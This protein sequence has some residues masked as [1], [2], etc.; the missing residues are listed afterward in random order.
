MIVFLKSN[1]CLEVAPR[2]KKI[3][4]PEFRYSED[5][6]FI[7]EPGKNF[8]ILEKKLDKITNTIRKDL[9]IACNIRET[10]YPQQGHMQL[11]LSYD[12]VTEIRAVKEL[13]IDI[14]G[15]PYVLSARSRKIIFT[16][17]DFKNL[18]RSLITYDLESI[19]VEKIIR[20]IDVV[21]E[22]RD[23]WDLLYLLKSKVKVTII[24]Q[25]YLEKTGTDIV[26]SDLIRA[27]KN[28]SYKKSWD[29]RL[30]NQMPQFSKYEEAVTEL[31]SFVRKN[32][33]VE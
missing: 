8:G 12:V 4:F 2:S 27:I 30:K 11:Y 18:N 20:I 7:A 13:K 17:N 25:S 23:L 32:F 33:E 5:L 9:P 21:Y 1:L 19:C 10:L 29:V 31:E 6:D 22:P 16:F 24:K 14:V 28:P 3:Y 26:T 15:D